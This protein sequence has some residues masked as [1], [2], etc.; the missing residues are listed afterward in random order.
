MLESLR[1][2]SIAPAV[3]ESSFPAALMPTSLTALYQNPTRLV[4]SPRDVSVDVRGCAI[5]AYIDYYESLMNMFNAPNLAHK[6]QS[7]CYVT[8]FQLA[9][10]VLNYSS[11]V[12]CSDLPDLF[13]CV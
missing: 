10:F 5:D 12:A 9:F 4:L 3:R 2:S 13:T 11:R 7:S 8:H 1:K 6:A